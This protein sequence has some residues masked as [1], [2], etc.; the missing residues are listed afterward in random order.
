MKTKA[1]QLYERKWRKKHKAKLRL[2]MRAWHKRHPGYHV[3]TYRE[4]VYGRGSQKH[5]ENRCIKQKGKCDICKTLM[6]KPMMD[7]CH[8]SSKWRGALCNRCNSGLGFIENKRWMKKALRYLEV[9][10]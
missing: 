6:V 2:Y 9:W 4:R 7:H 3:R 5:F 8:A 10:M 1:R